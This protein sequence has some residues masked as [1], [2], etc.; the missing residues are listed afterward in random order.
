M[1]V[2]PSGYADAVT[3]GKFVMGEDRNMKFASFLD[4][5]EKK[6]KA[7]GIF[8]VQKQNSNFT[9]EFQTLMADAGDHFPLATEATGKCHA[10]IAIL[11]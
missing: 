5:L 11:L 3:E 7:N 6:T 9:E 4:I 2:T 8:Y 10:F 1:T